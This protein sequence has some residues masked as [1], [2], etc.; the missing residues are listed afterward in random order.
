MFTLQKQVDISAYTTLKIKAKA[1]FLAVI[2]EETELQEALS[3]ARLQKLP[4]F[5]LG[6]GS[7]ILFTQKIKALV[8]KNEIKGVRVIKETET[9]VWVEARSG[10]WWS[11]LVRF[12]IERRWGG[13]E[14]LYYVPGTVGAAPVQN[15]GAYGVELKDTFVSLRAINLKTGK[16]K[17]FTKKDCAF[18]YR[19]SV[20]KNKEKGKYFIASVTLKLSKKPVLRLDYGDIRAQLNEQGI[21]RPSVQQLAEIIRK[22]RDNK[23]PNPAIY[24]NA[25][26]FFKNPEVTKADFVGLQKKFPEIK[27]FPGSK[28]GLVKIS[29]GWLIEQAGFKGKRYGP[30]GMYEKQALILV[31]YGGASAKQVLAH[32]RRVQA[33]VYQKFGIKI[34]PEVNII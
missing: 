32:V 3:W 7:N 14:N 22:I 8:L 10:E 28:S 9:S 11:T 19:S 25:G 30:V 20:F 1:A 16:E 29:A 18:G 34:E 17:I 15:I 6:G 23:L 24:P 21:K 26:S 33:G 5:I 27:F 2:K 31:N 12:A 13:I 4:V